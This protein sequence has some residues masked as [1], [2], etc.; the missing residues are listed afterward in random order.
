MAYFAVEG[1]IGAGK[2]TFLRVM[3]EA[4][5]M[6][7]VPEPHEA[8]QNINGENLLDAFYRDGKR[9]AYTFQTYVFITRII[10]AEEV[11]RS[12][13]RPLLLAERSVFA[14]RH[15]FAKNSHEIGL[16]NDLEWNLYREWFGWFVENRVTRP[17]GFI[18]L[19]AD[20]SI[21]YQRLAKRNRF[22][23][24]LVSL[25]YLKLLHAKHEAWL[26]HKKEVVAAVHDTP[27]LVL[28]CDQDFESNETLQ[29]SYAEQV[30]DFVQRS[31]GQVSGESVLAKKEHHHEC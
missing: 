23:E 4:L 12:S 11:A 19:R 30:A 6:Q 7:V 9:W 5:D 15:C 14:D 10:R 24:K 8:W 13:S 17:A 16:M 3:S 18:Y 22:E 1:N 2:T 25:D 28:D 21:C 20:P 29:R 27:I 31:T 26:I